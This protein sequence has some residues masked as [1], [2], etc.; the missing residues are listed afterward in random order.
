MIMVM[1]MVIDDTR[2]GPGGPA[3]VAPLLCVVS[4]AYV[5]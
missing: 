3:D 4:F 5:C 2:G 1:T